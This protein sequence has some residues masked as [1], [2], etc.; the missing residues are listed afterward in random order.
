MPF[1][2]PN[3]SINFS[4][5]TANESDYQ[6]GHIHILY[7]NIFD[8]ECKECSGQ[9]PCINLVTKFFSHTGESV[10]FSF[11]ILAIYNLDYELLQEI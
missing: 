8:D 9:G 5:L 2:N 7:G 11:F 6:S 4:K 3:P 10:Y 1:W